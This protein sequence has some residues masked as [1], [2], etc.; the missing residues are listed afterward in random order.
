MAKRRRASEELL[1]ARQ[2]RA[3]RP[4]LR[5]NSKAAA[6]EHVPCPLDVAPQALSRVPSFSHQG[7][8]R[9]AA[10]RIV[11]LSRTETFAA[12]HRLHSVQLTE[13]ENKQIFG[14]CNNVNGHG[15][16]YQVDVILRGKINPTTGMVVNLTDLKKYM[17]NAIMDPLDHKNLDKDV[18]FFKTNPSTCENV[19]VFIWDNMQAQLREQ[20][21]L[22]HEVRVHETAK[23]I[24]VYRG[25]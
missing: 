17:E 22:L 21:G 25:E 5:S 10:P 16:N 14:K 3:T 15:H 13:E 9:A 4:R 20:A 19:A 1:I 2:A 6:A 23:N 11:Y 8:A 7:H 12:C 24:A 18:D